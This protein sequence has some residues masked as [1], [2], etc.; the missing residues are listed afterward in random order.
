MPAA[1]A[2]QLCLHIVTFLAMAMWWGCGAL[3][4]VVLGPKRFGYGLG[5]LM[6]AIPASSLISFVL[7]RYFLLVIT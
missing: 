1:E 5:I 4:L 2:T 3:F 7:V 6:F